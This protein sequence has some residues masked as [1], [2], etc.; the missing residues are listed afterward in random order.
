MIWYLNFQ[1]IKKWKNTESICISILTINFDMFTAAKFFFFCEIPKYVQTR[2]NILFHAMG[3]PAWVAIIWK[4]A[5][6]LNG[7]AGDGESRLDRFHVIRNF[8][9][10]EIYRFST[11]S[12]LPGQ[13]A[14]HNQLL[15]QRL[16]FVPEYFFL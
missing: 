13:P 11:L 4:W 9:A 8:L 1:K 10:N 15:I 2:S 12:H 6:P 7:L 16:L 14:P 5:W 3:W